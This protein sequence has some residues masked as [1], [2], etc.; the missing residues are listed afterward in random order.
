VK[1]APLRGAV[2]ECRESLSGGKADPEPT[3]RRGPFV[4]QFGPQRS[5]SA[6]VDSDQIE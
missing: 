3:S 2:M 6:R 1:M 5:P 4:T